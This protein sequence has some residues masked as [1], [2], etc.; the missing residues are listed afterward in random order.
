MNTLLIIVFFLLGVVIGSFLNVVIFRLNTHKTFGGKSICL[1]CE[2]Y[3]YWYDLVPIFSYA[4]LKGRCRH[5]KSK[6]S[7]QYPLVELITGIVFLFLFLKFG[8]IFYVDPII[9]SLTYGFYAGIFSLLL[10][11]I[12][13]DIRHKI[14]PDVLSFFFGILAFIGVFLF[15]DFMLNPHLPKLYDF[16]G[17]LLSI[18]FALFWLV[19][20]GKWMGLG[21]AKLVIGLGLLLGL[22]KAIF[23]IMLAFWIG[24]IVGILLIIFKK[25]KGFKSEI[26]FAPF[27]ILGAFLAFVFDVYFLFPF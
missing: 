19:S 10:I 11:I 14:I 6:I 13:Y 21:D 17:L 8:Y 2:K 5:C 27:L 26:P 16:A 12:V 22:S 9:F 1:S 15:S 23:G 3:I 4:I 7:F 24:A 20:K 18:P 25:L